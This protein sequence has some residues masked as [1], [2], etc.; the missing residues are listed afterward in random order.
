MCARLWRAVCLQVSELLDSMTPDAARL[1]L[2]TR[3]YEEAKAAV[4]ASMPG[5]A[6]GS[7]PWFNFSFVAAELPGEL[8]QRWV[9]GCWR[10]ATLASHVT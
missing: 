8:R 4:L 9:G 5:A 10:E 7:E 2:C 3:Q 6:V 1:D